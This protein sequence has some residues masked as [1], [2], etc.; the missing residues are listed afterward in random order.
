MLQLRQDLASGVQFVV[1]VAVE[2]AAVGQIG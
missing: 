2:L 1:V